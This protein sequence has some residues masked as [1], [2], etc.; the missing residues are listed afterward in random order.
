MVIINLYSF[1]KNEK[2]AIIALA[3]ASA[4][5]FQG[6]AAQAE[7]YSITLDSSWY[8]NSST[9]YFWTGDAGASGW[10]TANNWKYLS[11]ATQQNLQGPQGYYYPGNKDTAFIGFNFSYENSQQV[12]TSMDSYTWTMPQWLHTNAPIYLGSNVTVSGSSNGFE[13]TVSL[14]F[15]DMALTSSKVS[16]GSFWARSGTFTFSGFLTMAADD[17]SYTLFEAT[18]M[19]QNAGTWVANFDITDQYGQSLTLATTDDQKGQAGYY[20]LETEGALGGN[21]AIK[22]VAKGTTVPEPATS[23]LSLLALAGLVVRRRRK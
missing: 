4:A 16:M 13:G 9:L 12:L 21:Y 19:V 10:S 1:N 2:L 8:S 11:N 22:L 18:S 17:F 14:N 5:Y 23:A 20:W 7:G 6:S 15:G 3:A